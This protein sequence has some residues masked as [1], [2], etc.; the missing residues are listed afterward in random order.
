MYIVAQRKH[1]GKRQTSQWVLCH[2]PGDIATN[3]RIA[4]RGASLSKL[5]FNVHFRLANGWVEINNH[6]IHRIFDSFRRF[7]WF[8]TRSAAC[9][10]TGPTRSNAKCGGVKMLVIVLHDWCT[11]T[12]YR[13][14]YKGIFGA[15]RPI[16]NT[17]SRPRSDPARQ[18]PQYST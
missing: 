16:L 5:R 1:G 12:I 6:R 15:M 8:C 11:E 18:F 9:V 2:A 3:Q 7:E 13:R 4:E 14:K 10:S 17:T